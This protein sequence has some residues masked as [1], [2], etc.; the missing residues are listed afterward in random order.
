LTAKIKIRAGEK[1]IPRK[2]HHDSNAFY[3][4]LHFGNIASFS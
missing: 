2:K 4:L 3:E 1:G